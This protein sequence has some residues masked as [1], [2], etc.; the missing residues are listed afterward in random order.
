MSVCVCVCVRVCARGVC[1][2]CACVGVCLIACEGILVLC[3]AVLLFVLAAFASLGFRS[4]LCF[5]RYARNVPPVRR[6]CPFN[7]Q[8]HWVCTLR[9]HSAPMSLSRHAHGIVALR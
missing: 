3:C 7:T 8:L 2:V 5:L 6:L 4:V 1:G 9:E